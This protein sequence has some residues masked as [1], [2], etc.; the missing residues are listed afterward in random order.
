MRPVEIEQNPHFAVCAVQLTLVLA[1]F[2][3]AWR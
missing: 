3:N 2:D 1:Y